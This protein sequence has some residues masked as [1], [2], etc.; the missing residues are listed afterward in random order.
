MHSF[1]LTALHKGVLRAGRIIVGKEEVSTDD[2][3]KL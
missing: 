2:V 1:N 3:T